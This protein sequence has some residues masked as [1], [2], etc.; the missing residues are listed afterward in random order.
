MKRIF[1]YLIFF[2]GGN[3]EVGARAGAA[4]SGVRAG[5]A[6]SATRARTRATL[7]TLTTRATLA[8]LAALTALAALSSCAVL[9]TSQV[10]MVN[11][12]GVASD[13]VAVGP[14][15]L[16][17]HLAEVRQERGLYFVQSLQSVDAHMKEMEALSQAAKTDATFLRKT[18]LYVNVLNSYLR[19]LRTL[20]SD[21]K[22]EDVGREVRGIGRGLDSLLLAYN[23]LGLSDPLVTGHATALGKSMGYLSQ[24]Y[25][26]RR[27]RALVKDFVTRGDTLAAAC[28]DALVDLLRKQEV[29][30]LIAH[31]ELGLQANYRAYV[32]ALQLR[33]QVPSLADERQYLALKAELEAARQTR[34]KCANALRSLR[35]AHRKVKAELAKRHTITRLYQE[36]LDLNTQAL[37]LRKTFNQV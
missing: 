15:V 12:L 19:A 9:T 37:A 24:E 14:V 25:V 29:E 28:C 6:G 2:F 21:A 8:T 10:E 18:D 7:A 5:A 26:K 16:F 36:I 30:E 33:G 27:Q 3:A 22:W 11:K 32:Q 13:S 20:S 23:Q 4:G 34:N 1:N 31:E 17:T 35:N